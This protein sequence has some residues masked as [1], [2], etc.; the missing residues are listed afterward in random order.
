MIVTLILKVSS[1]KFFA[2]C[3][4]TLH[5]YFWHKRLY[6]GEKNVFLSL[7]HKNEVEKKQTNKQTNKQKTGKLMKILIIETLKYVKFFI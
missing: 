6:Y 2:V 4:T 1:G 3:P 7:V 5:V